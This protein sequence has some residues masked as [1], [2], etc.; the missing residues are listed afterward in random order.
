MAA[1]DVGSG[2]QTDC[3]EELPGRTAAARSSPM[4]HGLT[5]KCLER[6]VRRG[7]TH[8]RNKV[9]ELEAASE[10]ARE[11]RK[12]RSGRRAGRVRPR[13]NIATVPLEV[14]VETGASDAKNL[15]GTQA[16]PVAQLENFLDMH[17][18]DSF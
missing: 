13:F 4:T 1:S 10:N 15:R 2:K 6:P 14:A 16:V 8:T 9:A 17:F 7:A 3:H 5:S 18:P 11:L 12:N